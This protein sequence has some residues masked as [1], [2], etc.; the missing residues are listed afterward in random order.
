MGSV[1]PTAHEVTGSDQHRAFHARL[2]NA[3]GFSQPL[4]V[5]LLPKPLRLCFTPVT[6]MGFALQRL[7]LLTSRHRLS[8]P[9]SPLDVL[10]GE[11]FATWPA[12]QSQQRA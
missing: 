5:L 10:V 9:P 6:L 4:D 7:P 2:R 8:T 1:A 3:F 11:S 12:R